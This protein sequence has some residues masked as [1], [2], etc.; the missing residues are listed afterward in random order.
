M[1]SRLRSWKLVRVQEREFPE[2]GSDVER[3]EAKRDSKAG[4]IYFTPMKP[5]VLCFV[6]CLIFKNSCRSALLFERN[7]S[8]PER[9]FHLK[10]IN[11]SRSGP[12]K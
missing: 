5:L 6:K 8:L 7:K 4:Q 9:N 1:G 10:E 2:L 3:R 12:K 11:L